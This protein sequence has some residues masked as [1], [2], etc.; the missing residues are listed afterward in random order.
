MEVLASGKGDFGLVAFWVPVTPSLPRLQSSP[1]PEDP[2]VEAADSVVTVASGHSDP[3]V[4]QYGERE[5][6]AEV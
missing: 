3:H 2:C 5:L 1:L 4:E 6:A